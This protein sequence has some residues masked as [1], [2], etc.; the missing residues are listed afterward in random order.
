MSVCLCVY[1][2]MCVQRLRASLEETIDQFLLLNSTHFAH[3]CAFVCVWV[4]LSAYFMICI[5]FN[6]LVCVLFVYC[7][8]FLM[9]HKAT[10][11]TCA[12]T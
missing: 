11:A 4:C 5:S 3:V 6:E 8:V 9:D 1:V 2:C 12:I 10:A 7:V